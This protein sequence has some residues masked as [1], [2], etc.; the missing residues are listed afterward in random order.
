MDAD[1]I[2]DAIFAVISPPVLMFQH[3]NR[4]FTNER[5][6]AGVRCLFID[7]LRASPLDQW[8]A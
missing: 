3:D 4:G 5:I 1:C 6:A 7:G 2:A 8:Y